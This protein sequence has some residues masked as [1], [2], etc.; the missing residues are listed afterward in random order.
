MAEVPLSRCRWPP[1]SPVAGAGGA[2]RFAA[3]LL[4]GVCPPLSRLGR[5]AALRGCARC[6]APR[7]FR[8]VLAAPSVAL[9]GV[10]TEQPARNFPPAYRGDNPRTLVLPSRFLL[11]KPRSRFFWCHQ[12]FFSWFRARIFCGCAKQMQKLCFQPTGSWKNDPASLL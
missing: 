8:G 9:R 4:G 10:S 6:A 1:G 3:A 12:L 7:T 11:L 2:P 5:A